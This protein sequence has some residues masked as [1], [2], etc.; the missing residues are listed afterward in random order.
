L[1]TATAEVLI[2]PTK[3]ALVTPPPTGT[4]VSQTGDP[5][6]AIRSITDAGNLATEK[7]TVVNLGEVVD[8]SGWTLTD[9][10]GN[11]Y[12]FPSLNLFQSGAISIHTALG[13]D[14]VT[15]LYWGQVGAMWQSGETATLKDPQGR[16]HTTFTAP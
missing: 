5:Q 10:Q 6:L 8:L 4:A 15:D 9:E 2:L 7:I 3:A 12:N 13:R 14:T 16:V 1:P 11:V